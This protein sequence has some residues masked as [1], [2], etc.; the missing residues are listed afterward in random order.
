MT[1]LGP[2]SPNYAT[3]RPPLD[4]NVSGVGIDTYFKDCTG[5]GTADGTIVTASWLNVITVQLREA[6]RAAGVTLDNT[7]DLMLS[8]AITATVVNAMG[9][10]TA[11]RGVKRVADDFSM[12]L[13]DGTQPVLVAAATDP[14]N[15]KLNVYD[16]SGG[17]IS[18][19]TIYDLVKAA[20][21]SA[22][23]VTFNDVAGTIQFSAPIHTVNP[24]PPAAPNV[25]DTWYDSDDDIL[26]KRTNDGTS[27]IWLQVA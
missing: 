15:D 14:L 4:P 9:S 3:T 5:P 16:V 8:Q 27:D 23:G 26:Y 24:V 19:I 1:A 20:L 2:Q 21:S 6:I 25:G 10:L 22:T 18:E 17:V 11:S 12:T 13:G 7:N